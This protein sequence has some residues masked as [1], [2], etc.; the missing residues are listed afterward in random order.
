MQQTC[1]SS[2]RPNTRSNQ[3]VASV[4]G[5]VSPVAVSKKY[6]VVLRSRFSSA[7]EASG[8]VHICQTCWNKVVRPNKWLDQKT[9]HAANHWAGECGKGS[10]RQRKLYSVGPGKKALIALGFPIGVEICGNHFDAAFP[11]TPSAR[12]AK[13][14]PSHPPGPVRGGKRSPSRFYRSAESNDVIQDVKRIAAQH[15]QDVESRVRVEV[16]KVM[17]LLQRQ[18]SSEVGKIL[19]Q[20]METFEDVKAAIVYNHEHVQ[21]QNKVLGRIEEVYAAATKAGDRS[22]RAVE[23]ANTARDDT[24]NS[25]NRTLAL[26]EQTIVDLKR[27]AQ[28]LSA[29]RNI[30]PAE[31]TAVADEEPAAGSTE[32]VAQKEAERGRP[33][34]KYADRGLES[35]S[36]LLKDGLDFSDLKTPPLSIQ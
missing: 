15:S 36:L 18:I 1:A 12:L 2:Q 14:P 20:P 24:V 17:G 10:S 5:G 23:A 35:L 26:K 33:P 32:S 4:G 31:A 6:L 29:R 11:P 7:L 8:S 30:W 25:S 34:P 28:L 3:K 19:R 21:E 16:S 9:C 13:T 27:K 22:A